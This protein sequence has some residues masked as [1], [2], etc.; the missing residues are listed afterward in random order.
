MI[1]GYRW[2]AA[3]GSPHR[4][5]CAAPGVG[6]GEPVLC[7]SGAVGEDWVG[8]SAPL[9]LDEDGGPAFDRR[10]GD[11]VTRRLVATG[12]VRSRRRFIGLSV[13]VIPSCEPEGNPTRIPNVL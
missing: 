3:L 9:N 10:C 7:G 11:C 1:D 8:P 4:A 13:A 5:H 6:L 2:V 12:R